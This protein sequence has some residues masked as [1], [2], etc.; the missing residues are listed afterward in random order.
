MTGLHGLTAAELR[1]ARTRIEAV[2]EGMRTYRGPNAHAELGRRLLAALGDIDV[3]Y[4]PDLFG[5][6]GIK[7]ASYLGTAY[8]GA[9]LE[10]ALAGGSREV[11]C[12]AFRKAS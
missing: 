10:R 3:E 5:S 6:G 11:L 2:C 8:S 1:T 4:W 9:K 12:S 7:G